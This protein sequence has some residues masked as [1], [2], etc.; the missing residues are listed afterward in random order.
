MT[1]KTVSESGISILT[2]FAA[3]KAKKKTFASTVWPSGVCI[4]ERNETN[5]EELL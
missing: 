3:D 1:E 4:I 2:C 5:Y